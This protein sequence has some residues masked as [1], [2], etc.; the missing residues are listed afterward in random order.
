MRLLI[1]LS[2]LSL[3]WSCRNNEPPVIYPSEKDTSLTTFS[4]MFPSG[5]GV[6]AQALS[7][8]PVMAF[9][10]YSVQEVID[11][12][13]ALLSQTFTNES[14]IWADTLQEVVMIWTSGYAD[15]TIVEDSLASHLILITNN[16][17]SITS[18]RTTIND[19]LDSLLVHR[20]DINAGG[21][22]GGS[23][24]DTC[25][26]TMTAQDS[27][28]F[29]TYNC[30]ST[31][32][33]TIVVRSDTTGLGGGGDGTSIT[34][35]YLAFS[36]GTSLVG[37]ADLTFTGGNT[38]N[39][40]ILTNSNRINLTGISGLHMQSGTNDWRHFGSAN[41]YYIDPETANGNFRIRALDNTST[42]LFATGSGDLVLE[43]SIW[44]KLGFK[45]GGGIVGSSDQVLT[46]TGTTTDWVS[47]GS[48]DFGL[49]SN[50]IPYGN[51]T[52][53][54]SEAGFEYDAGTNIMTVSTATIN[55]QLN[56]DGASGLRIRSAGSTNDWRHFGTGNNYFIEPETN[57]GNIIFRNQSNTQSFSFAV[58]GG[59]MRIDGGTDDCLG[60]N[61]SVYGTNAEGVLSIGSG[62]PPTTSITDGIQLYAEDVVDTTELKVRDEA[63]NIT[64]LSPHNF[65]RLPNGPSESLAWSYYSEKGDQYITVDMLQAI[66]TIEAQSAMIEELMCQ[67]A[68]IQN[69]AYEKKEPVQLVYKG[70]KE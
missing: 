31:L 68:E 52:G 63:G 38:L 34:D 5:G 7:V 28:I 17:D 27:F 14:I 9:D 40:N 64:T 19:I 4:E 21:G 66:R 33:D 36:N 35:T 67:L 8:K 15:S 70:R 41:D 62:T 10:H 3:V 58:N 45:D 49:T 53:F 1:Y 32:R 55:S 46:S 61:T 30:D 6:T 39:T 37:D 11:S 69:E 23:F 59:N 56:V 51:G 43:G 16:A 57:N 24:V 54:S 25:Y 65:S 12:G 44:P 47:P 60:V 50:E 18:H 26:H 13:F 48:I 2:I 42:F 22:G 20:T 29:L